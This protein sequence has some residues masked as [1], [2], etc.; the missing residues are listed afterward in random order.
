VF[1]KRI[2]I[3]VGL[4]IL[5]M[6]VLIGITFFWVIVEKLTGSWLF[7]LFFIILVFVIIL[8]VLFKKGILYLDDDKREVVEDKMNKKKDEKRRDRIEDIEKMVDEIG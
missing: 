1:G 3:A 4:F 2:L 6:V 7:S 5:T 8:V